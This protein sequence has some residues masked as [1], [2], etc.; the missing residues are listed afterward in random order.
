MSRAKL[1]IPLRGI[2]PPMITPLQD[3]DR[4]DRPGL[5][6]LVEH[7]LGGGVSSLF[8]LGSTGEAPGLTRRLQ[9]ELIESVCAQAA[10]RV[11]I[12]VGITSPCFAESLEIASV[13]AQAGASALVAAPPYY[14]P[15]SQSELLGYLGRLAP[16]LPLPLFLYNMPS[17]TKVS[18]EPETVAR[19]AELP[20]IVGF[21]DSSGSLDYLKRV[22]GLL[23]GRS[24]FS[25]LVGTEKLLVDAVRA[26]AH[27]GVTGGANLHPR[28]FVDIYNAAMEGNEAEAA[29]LQP[30]LEQLGD[31]IYRIVP[32]ASSY[33]RGLKCSLSL[34]GLCVGHL[35][36]PYRAYGPEE[37]AQVRRALVRLGL[38]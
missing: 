1:P 17:L 16:A 15:T 12:L 3:E 4:L 21:K 19:A 2:V 13:A 27:G 35:A 7:M 14:F 18:F 29:R 6:R 10:D 9:G 26:G 20:N 28:L 8:V 32:E 24:E 5:E 33:L 25:L 30:R 23:R 11:P 22:C 36:E 31:E 34:V 37:T 38:L